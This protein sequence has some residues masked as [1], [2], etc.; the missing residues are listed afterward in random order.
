[1]SNKTQYLEQIRS[2]KKTLEDEIR[3]IDG[4]LNDVDKLKKSYTAENKKLAEN[5]KI[6][7]ISDYEELKVTYRSNLIKSIQECNS[8]MEP[9]NY[10]SLKNT[11]VESIELIEFIKIG[12]LSVSIVKLQKAILLL[13]SERIKLYNSKKELVNAI[14]RFRYYKNIILNDGTLLK[15]NLELQESINKFEEILYAKASEVKAIEQLSVIPKI[16]AQVLSNIL[17]TKIIKLEDIE[18]IFN[19]INYEINIKV[20]DDDDLD[21]ELNYE[22]IE[23]LIVKFNKK[24]K[25]FL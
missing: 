15:D 16:N 24:I 23:G 8:K 18:L 1:I 12:E 19:P 2:K 13:L 4:I 17:D 7:S 14:Y 20:N 9:K 22:R 3:K 11:L 5:K 10:L 25:L 6:F 21:K